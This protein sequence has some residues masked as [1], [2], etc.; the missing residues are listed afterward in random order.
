MQ[1]KVASCDSNV[2]SVFRIF[3]WNFTFPFL[4]VA[5]PASIFRSTLNSNSREN[6]N[7]NLLS[8]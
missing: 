6:K 3:S 4:A 2:V 1:V 8:N 7:E 5:W